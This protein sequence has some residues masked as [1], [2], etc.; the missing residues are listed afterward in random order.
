[1]C[2]LMHS[3]PLSELSIFVSKG[4]S[5]MNSEIAPQTATAPLFH[6]HLRHVHCVATS[7]HVSVQT[8]LPAIEPPQWATVSTS[9][10]PGSFG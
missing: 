5:R 4:A 1:M 8:K 9:T 7:V 2:P 3:P 10:W 6:T